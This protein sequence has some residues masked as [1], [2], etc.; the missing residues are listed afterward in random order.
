MII[1]NIP[2]FDVGKQNELSRFVKMID[3]FY[4]HRVRIILTVETDVNHLFDK[5]FAKEQEIQ[6][7]L[8]GGKEMDLMQKGRLSAISSVVFSCKRTQSRLI[9]MTSQAYL[10]AHAK[11]N[12]GS[13]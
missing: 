13:E 5:V 10:Q 9:E 4:D 1:R 8:S 12:E 3:Q 6:Q 2:Q 7:T 11:A